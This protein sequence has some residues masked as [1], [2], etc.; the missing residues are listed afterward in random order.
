MIDQWPLSQPRKLPPPTTPF[1]ACEQALLC[2]PPQ[3][4]DKAN[5]ANKGIPMSP[6]VAICPLLQP[7][8]A[9]QRLLLAL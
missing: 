2:R 4:Y 8:V 1:L 5:K 6:E 7:C 3:P 9:N